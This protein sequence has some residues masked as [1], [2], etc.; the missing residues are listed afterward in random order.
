MKLELRTKTTETLRTRRNTKE[1][2][3][4]QTNNRTN[5][6]RIKNQNH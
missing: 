2:I 4:E 1:G 3:K 6:V 5:E